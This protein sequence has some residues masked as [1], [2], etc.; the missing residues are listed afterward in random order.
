VEARRVRVV[1][2]A[3]P[4]SIL[5]LI[6]VTDAGY[7]REPPTG[8]EM[9]RDIRKEPFTLNVRLPIA[10]TGSITPP[11]LTGDFTDAGTLPPQLFGDRTNASIRHLAAAATARRELVLVPDHVHSKGLPKA[12]RFE[13]VG[14]RQ[15]ALPEV[16]VNRQTVHLDLCS[17]LALVRV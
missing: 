13:N 11:V 7:R 6:S 8:R 16:P 9:L 2:F 12:G 15:N 14:R 5:Q 17:Q 10:P 4:A 3:P 1:L